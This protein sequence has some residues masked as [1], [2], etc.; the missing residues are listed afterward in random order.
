VPTWSEILGELNGALPTQGPGAF[1]HVRRKYLVLL[2]NH[3]KR[4]T[5][6]YATKWTQPGVADASQISITAEDMQG[7]M[8]VIHGLD[9]AAGL[10][11]I[12]HSPGGSPDAA[13]AI[14]HYIRSKFD[15]VRVIVPQAAMSAA[16]MVACAADEI[17]MGKHSSLGPI[18]PQFIVSSPGGTM[19]LPAQA[20]LDQFEMAKDDCKD[21][22]LLGAWMPIL[23]QYGPSLLIQ[24]HNALELAEELA[25]EWLARWMFRATPGGKNVAKGIAR[26]LADHTRYKSHGRPIHRDVAR[27]IGLK[28]LDLEV[29]QAV[30]D[31]VLSVF[32]ASTHTFASTNAVKIIENQHGRAFVKLQQLQRVGPEVGQTAP[33]VPSR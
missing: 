24:C 14:V 27:K 28:V 15:S 13:E 7:F 25:S 29:D 30:Q 8:E 31:L 3:T 5:I 2:S 21:S 1:D 6:L 18:D 20:I 19:A 10:D 33:L 17:V 12:L 26:K 16:T 23:P 4:N 9:G 22:S 11:L 32:H